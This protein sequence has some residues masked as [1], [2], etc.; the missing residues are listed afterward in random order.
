[1]RLFAKLDGRLDRRDRAALL[2]PP[3]DLRMHTL[4]LTAE[5]GATH[6]PGA[7]QSDSLTPG[8][9]AGQSQIPGA[10]EAATHT[11]GALA[12]EGRPAGAETG[13]SA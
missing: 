2:T 1:M 10:D 3:F 4:T 13:E 8:A 5:A 9:R 12:G 11:P 7:E 6:V